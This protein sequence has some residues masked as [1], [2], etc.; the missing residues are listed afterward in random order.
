MEPV[1]QMY[2]RLLNEAFDILEDQSGQ[3]DRYKELYRG[4]TKCDG[5]KKGKFIFKGFTSTSLSPTTAFNFGKLNHISNCIIFFVIENAEGLKLSKFSM[6][7][8]EEEVLMKDGTTLK[9]TKLYKNYDKRIEGKLKQIG[10]TND[11]KVKI[12]VQ[13]TVGKTRQ[14][15][16]THCGTMNAA[17]KQRN[18]Y[19]KMFTALALIIS[20][21]II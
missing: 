2:T 13:G 18:E 7:P 9:I 6:F 5:L 16:D 4:Q 15:R 19:A 14:K 1:W 17:S 3:C 20:C 10:F 12:F 8:K 11:K 21:S